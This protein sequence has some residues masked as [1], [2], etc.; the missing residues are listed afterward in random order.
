MDSSL[1]RSRPGLSF[2]TLAPLILSA[3]V[4]VVPLLIIPGWRGD[5]EAWRRLV[6][7]GLVLLSGGAWT[8]A[9][10][11]RGRLS[12]PWHPLLAATVA[13]ALA[14]ALAAA[15]VGPWL[16][17]LWGGAL[18]P[19]SILSWLGFALSVALG[20][21]YFSTAER[22]RQLVG[23]ASWG[24]G[25]VLVADTLAPLTGFPFIA[26]FDDRLL[27]LGWFIFLSWWL[28]TRATTR[29]AR[30]FAW[31]LFSLSLLWW[32][33]TA[34]AVW[35][36]LILTLVGLGWWL[37]PWIIGQRA[38]REMRQPFGVLSGLMVAA[39][40]FYYALP[41]VFGRLV[42]FVASLGLPVTGPLPW[43]WS[44]RV[45]DAAWRLK[46]L[47]GVGLSAVPS[48]VASQGVGTIGWWAAWLAAGGLVVAAAALALIFFW[49]RTWWQSRV[50]P[51]DSAGEAGEVAWLLGALV[52]WS[53]CS[54]LVIAPGLPFLI[55]IALLTGA[56]IG[57]LTAERRLNVKT[58]ALVDSSGRFH[59]AFG[60]LVLLGIVLLATL[61]ISLRVGSGLVL[62][63]R[64]LRLA[65]IKESQAVT[66]VTNGLR[67]APSDELARLLVD[68]RLR[69]L[70][71]MSSAT[72]T[73]E[74]LKFR[75]KTTAE[76]AVAAARQALVWA[77]DAPA[78]WLAAARVSDALDYY[79]VG[80]A[81]AEAEGA[82]GQA[83][84][85]APY[86][87]S[88][89]LSWA[90][91]LVRHQESASAFKLLEEFLDRVPT[92]AAGLAALTELAERQNNL[93]VVLER[94]DQALSQSPQNPELWFQRG[95]VHYRRG[96][97]SLA[98]T[99]LSR[100]LEL[101]PGYANALYF[102]GLGYRALG[103]RAAAL[104]DWQLVN[105]L[106]PGSAEIEAALKSLDS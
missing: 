14:Q 89:V 13:L 19:G 29:R 40:A 83:I 28:I 2:N 52:A 100:A 61:V 65:P 85:L 8:I 38:R 62:V 91:M 77:P 81:K 66:M 93:K 25:A 98:V 51:S 31:L 35:F 7:V 102:R 43:L 53:W 30:F 64:G 17:A 97:Y 39:Y 10:F 68:W 88:P 16:Y 34:R 37:A 63:E 32:L 67:L 46:P 60:G 86:D 57:L 20:A 104:A 95:Y 82:Y 15:S 48:L 73:T 24:F 56:W 59:R 71:T 11:Q 69:E 12:L 94:Y 41:F 72:T 55:L 78:N 4:L 80:G 90:T 87:L 105:Q 6:V 42:G 47:T 79:G 103:N 22:I 74:E 23:L 54:L 99:D 36:P 33:L 9:R 21:Y 5:L 26:T 49:L 45:I 1:V 27:V 58:W 18:G 101:S 76:A 50:R 84:R 96:E 44:G 70:A 106:N 92:S 3:L 75:F